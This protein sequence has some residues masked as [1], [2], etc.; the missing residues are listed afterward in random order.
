ME[1]E[2]TLFGRPV[3]TL[4]D[5]LG[6]KED[7][8]TYSFGWALAQ[9]ERLTRS[10]LRDLFPGRKI[11]TPEVIRL[12][13]IVPHAGR[14]DIEIVAGDVHVVLE[15]KRGWHLPEEDQLRTYAER[16]DMPPTA[17][18]VTAEASQDFV[19]LHRKLPKRV[20]RV[21]VLY[22]SWQE[23][24]ELAAKTASSGGGSAEKRL[25]RELV[26]YMKGLMTM[27]N[28]RDNMV[29]VV[30]LSAREI[31][32]SG[33]TYRDPVLQHNVYFCPFGGGWPVVPP[34]YL[35]FRFDGE[36][37]QIRH[38]E[39][40]EVN[41]SEYSGFKPLKG[42]VQWDDTPHWLFQL[43]PAIKPPRQV[44]GGRLFRGQRVWAALDLLLTSETVSEA[45]DKTQARL[46]AAGEEV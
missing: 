35:G 14:T 12:Q 1:T 19:R 38:V 29:F 22:R 2:I 42:K 6:K 37:Q 40:Y 46:R 16:S 31:E 41:E 4:F 25:L 36:L 44:K 33:L 27:Q 9:S 5:L 18:L 20:S 39:G 10:L 43:G 30:S 26:T 28:V 11:T 21:P 34:N 45:R 24:S 13:E 32:N 15:A 17:L 8:I 3:N 23:L 7:D